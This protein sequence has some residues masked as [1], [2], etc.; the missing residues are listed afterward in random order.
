M[1]RVFLFTCAQGSRQLK[2]NSVEL[3]KCPFTDMTPPTHS[4]YGNGQKNRKKR[5]KY[6]AKNHTDFKIT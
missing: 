5:K 3:Q 2:I 6:L 1:W 4:S